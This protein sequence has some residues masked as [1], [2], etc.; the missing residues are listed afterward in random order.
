[1]LVPPPPPVLVPLPPCKCHR[2]CQ[3]RAHRL[4]C[5]CRHASLELRPNQ[6]LGGGTL[7]APQPLPETETTAS[8]V[9]AGQGWGMGAFCPHLLKPTPPPPLAA[10]GKRGTDCSLASERSFTRDCLGL[11][12]ERTSWLKQTGPRKARPTFP[13]RLQTRGAAQPQGGSRLCPPLP[14]A[15]GAGAFVPHCGGRETRVASLRKCRRPH[16]THLRT[17]L[18]VCPV[19]RPVL[20]LKDTTRVT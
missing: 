1:M 8:T 9:G 2:H 7:L 13:S 4:C 19:F 17:H 3:R 18:R 16:A 10:P 6:H 20:F 14:P 5:R 12:W 15:R 11:S